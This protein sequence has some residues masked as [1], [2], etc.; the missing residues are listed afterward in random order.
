MSRYG[1]KNLAARGTAA[2]IAKMVERLGSRI[3]FVARAPHGALPWAA[4]YTSP[5]FRST[6]APVAN[7]ILYFHAGGSS[8]FYKAVDGRVQGTRAP[9]GSSS[10][11][12]NDEVAEWSAAG[13][14]THVCLYIDPDTLRVFSEQHAR[15]GRPAT[16]NPFFSAEDSWLKAFFDMLASEAEVYSS[17]SDVVDSLLLDQTQQ[18]VLRHLVRWHSDSGAKLRVPGRRTEALASRTLERI[19]DYVRANISREIGLA[20]LAGLANL[21]E[22]HLIRCFS[23]ATGKTPYQYVLDERLKLAAHMLRTESCTILEVAARSGFNSSSH[24]SAT[25]RTRFGITPQRYR[26]ISN[27]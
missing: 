14:F 16:V 9:A 15:G 8:S 20:E 12:P 27:L 13:T 4:K 18:L 1:S 10:F 24:F 23:A 5:P 3:H 21:S 22:H 25:F 26:A 6:S 17:G 11:I 2:Q 19:Y 7:H